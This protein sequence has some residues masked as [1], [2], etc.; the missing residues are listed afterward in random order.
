MRWTNFIRKIVRTFLAAYFW[1]GPLIELSHVHFPLSWQ[2]FYTRQSP[3]GFLLLFITYYSLL[4]ESGWFS[5]AY[6]LVYI[7]LWPLVA[8]WLLV[9]F[10]SVRAYRAFKRA[11]FFEGLI[12]PKIAAAQTQI[13]A[14]Q[15][16]IAAAQ[17][18]NV[19]NAKGENVPAEENKGKLQRL[20]SVLRPFSQFFLLWALLLLNTSNVFLTW[21]ALAVILF[22]TTTIIRTLSLFLSDAGSWI[23]KLKGNF[24]AQVANNVAIV[25]AYKSSQADTPSRNAANAL[26]LYETT[27]RYM[28]E[29]KERLAR[30]TMIA[31]ILITIPLYLYL[32]LMFTSIYL[33]VARLNH[34]A[35]P[36]TD[37]LT[38]SIF[39]P[40][41]YTDLP[42][43]LWI[44][45]IGGCQVIMVTLLGYTVLFRR[46]QS[47]MLQ[48]YQA[49]GE[50][51]EPLSD[52]TLR[53]ILQRMKS[54]NATK[55]A[56]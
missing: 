6:D 17:T 7:Y 24:A 25:R 53:D 52:Q 36:W 33:G 28:S 54:Q 22:G 35:W 27:F 19:L 50:L 29:N 20:L 43:N 32:S 38:T 10:T 34:I 14:A 31:S 45:L 46:L 15:T 48:L 23:A 49:A 44:R 51:S 41:A 12:L 26:L 42:H 55:Q 16:Q 47:S 3:E 8:L 5:V 37:A 9:K 21:I 18:Q 40:F 2:H 1:L 4:G 30:W 39:I 11:S 13:A 56:G